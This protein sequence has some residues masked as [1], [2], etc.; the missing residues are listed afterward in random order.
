MGRHAAGCILLQSTLPVGAHALSAVGCDLLPSTLAAAAAVHFDVFVVI[1]P[2]PVAQGHTPQHAR[3]G[4][5]PNMIVALTGDLSLARS[6]PSDA[7]WLATTVG[8]LPTLPALY[9]SSR[10]APTL[11]GVPPTVEA[12]HLPW[13]LVPPLSRLRPVSPTRW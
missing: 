8:L 9:L 10:M 5:L 1:G 2:L 11:H 13:P 4:L 6:I 3:A 7:A 12:L